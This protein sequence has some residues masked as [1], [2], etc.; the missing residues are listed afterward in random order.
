[1]VAG[2]LFGL[3]ALKKCAGYHLSPG[4]NREHKGPRFGLEEARTILGVHDRPLFASIVKPW[5]R[6]SR[7]P[8]QR[9][10]CA[11]AWTWSRT[12][13]HSKMSLE[14]EENDLSRDALREEWDGY[15]RV[16]P[17]A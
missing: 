17:V 15:K 1:M 6:R 10:R 7:P 2:N 8:W 4:H 14:W 5:I 3:G 12:T 11:A 16:F 13:R 9:Q